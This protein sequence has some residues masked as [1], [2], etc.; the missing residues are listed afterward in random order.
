MPGRSY[1]QLPDGSL[2]RNDLAEARYRRQ[3]KTSSARP[4]TD[5]RTE[6]ERDKGRIYYSGY[7]ARL[8]GVTQLMS[9][10]LES[11][12]MHSRLAHSHK[13]AL[14]SGEIATDL[15]RRA[16]KE[17][18][19]RELILHLGGIDIAACEAA[20]LAHD[21]GHPPFGHVA[22]R[23]LD[24]WVTQRDPS[25]QLVGDGFEGNAQSL[26][27]LTTLDSQRQGTS[28]L[29]LTSVTLAAIQKY[30]WRRERG[31][32]KKDQKFS[33]YTSDS[34][35]L[36]FA[37]LS[38]PTE[39][40]NGETQ[41]LEASIMDLADDITYALHD[42]QDALQISLL[43]GEAVVRDLE[44]AERQLRPALSNSDDQ[45]KELGIFGTQAL[46]LREHHQGQYSDD[47]WCD[48]LLAVAG[49]IERLM[50]RYN[51]AA[52][53]DSKMRSG[54]ARQFGIYLSSVIVRPDPI[55]NGGPHLSIDREP[56]H[57]VQVLKT[58]S[59]NYVIDSPTIGIHQYAQ[60]AALQQMLKGMESWSHLCPH[61]PSPA[62]LPKPLS[63]YMAKISRGS[64]SEEDFRRAVA[65][66]ACF[67]T[68]R[69]CLKW[70]RWFGGVEL[71]TLA[72]WTQ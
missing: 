40:R 72:E 53:D 5:L 67:L 64:G 57:E 16:A 9:P 35:A 26:R 29:D 59:K 3:H 30:P 70:S 10:P 20:G 52:L 22:E 44:E 41:S 54:F 48:A 71:P 66:Y 11:S 28:G 45:V 6:T 50:P 60:R 62:E 23:I 58:I 17:K 2:C 33:V 25:G 37:R 24:E 69:A 61:P 42:I 18:K 36:E 55:W 65:D 21:I 46:K 68:D 49:L 13:V 56:W 1:F 7:L 39:M 14:V 38:L 15:V 19:L 31:H 8:A 27:V 34:S 32:A 43:N 47:L 63:S 51:D 12:T 4:D